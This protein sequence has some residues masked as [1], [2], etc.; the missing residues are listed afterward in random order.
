MRTSLIA[1]AIGI[2]LVMLFMLIVYRIPGLVASIALCFY[3][4]IEA[5][6]FSLVRVNL[7]L[8]GIAGIILS[9]GMA[10]EDRQERDRLRLQACVHRDP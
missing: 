10:V 3:M 8:P 4:V 5:L 9:I 6:I 1:G 7:S 2:V